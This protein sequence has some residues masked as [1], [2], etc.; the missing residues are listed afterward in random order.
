ML[1]IREHGTGGFRFS[2]EDGHRGVGRL[3]LA[4]QHEENEAQS[5]RCNDYD[6]CLGGYSEMG[7]E[8]VLDGVYLLE[9]GL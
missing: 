2:V 4:N 3:R 9:E 8:T 5:N 7:G 6:Y 1:I